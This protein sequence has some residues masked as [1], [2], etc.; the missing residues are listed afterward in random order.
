MIIKGRNYFK[1]LG[2]RID[3]TSKDKVLR[4]L[5]VRLA[6]FDNKSTK[7]K[8]FF[9]T[10]PNPEQLVLAQRDFFFKKILNSADLSLPDGIGVVAAQKFLELPRAKNFFFSLPL[11]FAQGLGVGF[12]IIFDRK[13]LESRLSV[14]RGRD[15]FVES[16]KL[17]NKKGWR[18]FLVGNREKSAQK[19]CF[20]LRKNF[21]KVKLFAHEGPNLDLEARPLTGKDELIEKNLIA[22]INKVSPH[23]I[24]VGFGAPK[25]EKWLYRYLSKL[26]AGVVMVVGG[27]FD[28]LSGKT[29]IPPRWVAD[30]GLEWLWRLLS[31]SQRWER[32]R[33]ALLDFPLRVFLEKLIKNSPFLDFEI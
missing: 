21:K 29:K 17:A 26:N 7:N 30:T 27:T 3:S 32:V 22:K 16:I 28:Y 4:T 20:E 15:L 13:W 12:S 24:F 1:I 9:I 18:V 33:V 8:V 31:G 11:Y 25:Q 10:T 6:R 23:F 14:I 2:I 19:A 5:F